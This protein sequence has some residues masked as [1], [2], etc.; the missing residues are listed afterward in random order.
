MTDP[1]APPS[2]NP[3][4]GTTPPPQGAPVTLSGGLPHG[5]GSGWIAAEPVPV[6]PPVRRPWLIPVIVGSSILLA[7]LVVAG[8]TVVAVNLLP[9]FLPTPSPHDPGSQ[10]IPST[11]DAPLT[12]DPGTPV[13]AE[14]LTCSACFGRDELNAL[15]PSEDDVAALGFTWPE[16][17][18]YTASTSAEQEALAD[19]WAT[20]GGSPDSCYFLYA[21][22]PLPT[23]VDAT[24]YDDGVVQYGM[25][26]MDE[27][28]LHGLTTGSRLFLDSA[29]AEGQLAA[30]A[31]TIDDCPAYSMSQ[32]GWGGVVTPSPALDLPASVAGYGWTDSSGPYRTYA[33]D[34]QR[35][36]LVARIRLMTDGDGPTEE[37]F[38]DYVEV[39]AEQIAGFEP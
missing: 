20:D 37:Q 12:G 18:G 22:A 15:D 35:G 33:F 27:E 34:L 25:T 30:L 11:P 10:P 13:A 17:S 3:L 29:V 4:P 7:G 5:I 2:P 39:V 6:R 16:Y 32:L 14:P 21:W 26:W 31:A 23:T 24:G 9:V 36:N 19:A 8:I 1:F 28:R 38:R